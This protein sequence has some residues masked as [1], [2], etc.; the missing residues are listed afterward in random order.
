MK[1]RF[2]LALIYS[3]LTAFLMMLAFGII[4]YFTAKYTEQEFFQ[5]LDKRVVLTSQIYLQKE[6]V[7]SGLYQKI[8]NDFSHYL[9]TEFDTVISLEDK[10]YPG[11]SKYARDFSPD[12]LDN[13][14]ENG[15]G[16]TTSENRQVVGLRYEDNEG[17]YLVLA[18]AYD[19]EGHSELKRLR[20]LLGIILLSSTILTFFVGLFYARQILK[21]ISNII[22][23]VHR[24]EAS[25]LST[26]LPI[27]TGKDELNQL[28]ST[29]NKMLARLE[30][31]FELQHNFVSH[32]S[33]EFHNPL[34]VILG[35][36][37]VATS[38]ERSA[39]DYKESLLKIEKEAKRLNNLTESLLGLAQTSYSDKAMRR[40]PVRVDELM[41][42]VTDIVKKQNPDA[43]IEMDLDNLPAN[44]EELIVL[45]NEDLLRVALVNVVDNASKFSG[46]ELVRIYLSFSVGKINIHITD[47][48]VGIPETEIGNIFEPFFRGSNVR[49]FK[50]FGIGLPLT[51]KIIKLHNGEILVKSMEKSGTAVIISLP[52]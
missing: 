41:M 40:R 43:K 9:P 4:Y 37:E 17:I 19:S 20:K 28:A 12:F 29:F 2:K 21:P 39:E 6:E 16:R 31:S 18:S 11:F 34:S 45:M 44:E 22:S 27:S 42:E 14:D 5:Y 35:E 46:N 10:T 33:H 1:L 15:Y 49:K 52:R 50:G 32:A 3:L 48:G 30:V 38:R 26:R 7:T 23:R 25:N 47:Q 51:Q 36:I 13:V 24:I 8:V